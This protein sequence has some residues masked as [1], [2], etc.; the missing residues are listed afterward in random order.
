MSNCLNLLC[1]QQWQKLSCKAMMSVNHQIPPGGL[2]NLNCKDNQLLL[3]MKTFTQIQMKQTL[4]QTILT[5]R[6]RISTVLQIIYPINLLLISQMNNAVDHLG[7]SRDLVFARI[8]LYDCEFT[9]LDVESA[10]RV[11]SH[12]SVQVNESCIGM[13][14]LYKSTIT[15]CCYDTKLEH[16][17]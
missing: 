6:T 15:V 11:L 14:F 9:Q 10:C 1:Q 8:Q 17:L 12:Q 4:K 7:R 5:W 2:Q 16:L 3:E 13:T